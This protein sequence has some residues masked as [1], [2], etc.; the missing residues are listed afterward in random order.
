MVVNLVGGRGE[1]GREGRRENASCAMK[2]WAWWEG[3]AI[4]VL[5]V[6]FPRTVWVYL[7]V[8]YDRTDRTLQE[9]T[10]MI[11]AE[12]MPATLKAQFP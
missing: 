7:G 4:L 2:C 11:V 3:H 6:P 1:G 12:C 10:S 8:L 9:M 5:R